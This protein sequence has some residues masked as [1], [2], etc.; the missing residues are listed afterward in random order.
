MRRERTGGS[1]VEGNRCCI[2][3]EL[4]CLRHRVRTLP[5]QIRL[6]ACVVGCNRRHK[7]YQHRLGGMYT[8]VCYSCNRKHTAT[9][10]MCRY[11]TAYGKHSV[12]HLC[13]HVRAC[14]EDRG[15]DKRQC[16]APL[17]HHLHR[18]GPE[19]L[20]PAHWGSSW[21]WHEQLMWCHSSGSLAQWSQQS[22]LLHYGPVLEIL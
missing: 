15:T 11:S 9:V 5:C 6:Q 18:A 4:G 20:R 22:C 13:T 16:W 19:C 21:R 10:R 7:A 17:S 2:Q 8:P 3:I 12:R 1:V 14:L